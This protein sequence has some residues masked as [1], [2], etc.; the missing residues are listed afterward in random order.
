MENR[1]PVHDLEREIEE[2]FRQ[3]DKGGNE[4][5]SMKEMRRMM[6][7]LGER[8]TDDELDNMMKEADLNGDG[9]IGFKG[10]ITFGILW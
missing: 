7:Q 4:R 9:Q 10:E 8:L 6:G 5:I 2:A 1:G 3:F